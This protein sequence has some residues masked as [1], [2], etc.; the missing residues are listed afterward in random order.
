MMEGG[1]IRWEVG[2]GCEGR[3]GWQRGDKGMIGPGCRGR[4]AGDTMVV[5]GGCDDERCFGDVWA[6]HLPTVTW[7]R[8]RAPGLRPIGPCRWGPAG[9][10]VD[11]DDDGPVSPQTC[12]PRGIAGAVVNRRFLL[13]I[14]PL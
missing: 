13:P 12:F 10:R 9:V 5:F 3:G 2:S 14:R 7:R 1:G 6:L 8:L 11:L 4:P